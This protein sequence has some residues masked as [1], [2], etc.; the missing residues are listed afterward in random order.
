MTA[1]T[2]TKN[3]N[4]FG[5]RKFVNFQSF[6]SLKEELPRAPGVY[7]IY[8]TCPESILEKIALRTSK[9]HYNFNSK[10]IASRQIPAEFRISQKENNPYCI[11]NGHTYNLR[12]RINEHFIGTKGTGCLA[13]FTS[14]EL[15]DYE[16]Y[17]E[18]LPL[19][20]LSLI[21]I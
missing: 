6:T 1:E 2:L 18:Y 7:R 10:I 5:K 19:N 16:W 20:S 3:W 9:G 11:Y 17:I 4:E 14:N 21:H 15:K 13:I 12:Q 8:T